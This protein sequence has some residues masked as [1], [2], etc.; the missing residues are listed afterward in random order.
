ME[1]SRLRIMA[2]QS[3]ME[4]GGWLHSGSI[5]KIEP[6]GFAEELSIYLSGE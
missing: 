1:E 5:L 2:D 3:K 4:N 6:T